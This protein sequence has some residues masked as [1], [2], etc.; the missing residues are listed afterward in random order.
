MSK[1]QFLVLNVQVQVVPIIQDHAHVIFV[2]AEERLSKL[3]DQF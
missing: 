1:R 2:K 3:P